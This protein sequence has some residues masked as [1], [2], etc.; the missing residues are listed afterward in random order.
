MENK[1]NRAGIYLPATVN[2]AKTFP[3][4]PDR[5]SWGG[6]A[7]CDN[8]RGCERKRPGWICGAWKEAEE[9]QLKMEGGNQ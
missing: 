1:K 7:M 2:P 3:G 6:K 8:C 9:Y 5:T 4:F